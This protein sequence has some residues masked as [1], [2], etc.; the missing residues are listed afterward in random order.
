MADKNITIKDVAAA[1]GVSK[2]TVDRVVHNRGEVSKESKEK[3]LKVIRELGYTPNLHASMLAS[4]RVRKFVCLIPDSKTGELWDLTQ[5]GILAGGE[6]AVKLNIEVCIVKYDQF[7]AESFLK[8]CDKVLA[9]NPSGVILP[10]IFEDETLPFVRKLQA[11]G[12]PYIYINSKLKADKEDNSGYAAYFGMPRYLSGYLCA[13]LLVGE[14][15]VERVCIIRIIRDKQGHS[16]PTSRRREG[17]VSYFREHSPETE[18]DNVFVYPNDPEDID[19]KIAG[20]M[21]SHP[22]TRHFVML[23]SRVY[24]V[25]DFLRRQ[26]RRMRLVGFDI[27]PRNIEALKDGLIDIIIAQRIDAEARDAIRCLTDMVMFNRMPEKR[28]SYTSMDILTKYNCD[29]Y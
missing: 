3:V 4:K 1:A 21:D 17:F 22:Q 11:R 12:I 9:M 15:K 19:S 25:S 26:G 20:Y 8:A 18:I 10:P 2:G 28:D 13:D 16:D 7:S 14:E 5:H 6:K 29:Y 23:N 27:L 24:L